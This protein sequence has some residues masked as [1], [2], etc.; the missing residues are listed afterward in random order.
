MYNSEQKERYLRRQNSRYFVLIKK[1]L[2][3]AEPY[4]EELDLD[5]SAFNTKD[6]IGMY[7]RMNIASLDSIN[8]KNSVFK[9]Y[10]DWCLSENM[11]ADGINHYD[12]LNYEHMAKCVNKANA[13]KKYLTREDVYNIIDDLQNPLEKVLVLAAYE[14]LIMNAGYLSVY[15]IST[16]QLDGNVFVGDQGKFFTLSDDIIEYMEEAEAADSYLAYTK[17]GDIKEFQFEEG[18]EYVF[19]RMYNVPTRYTD[20]HHAQIYFIRTFERIRKEIDR[21]ADI[22]TIKALNESGRIDAIKTYMK[23]ENETNPQV[24]MERHRDEL[25]STYGNVANIKRYVVKHAD[26]FAEG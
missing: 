18:N 26:C 24:V 12:E 23:A 13:S 5:C 3:S 2:E 1:V 11:V 20:E 17:S 7:K 8:N 21:N 15:N 4:E 16:E 14:G 10:T 6:I 25:N 19:K 22:L 9:K